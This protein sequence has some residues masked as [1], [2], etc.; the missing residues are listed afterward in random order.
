MAR[1]RKPTS[2]FR[3][4]NSSPEVIC[5]VVMMYVKHPLSLRSA[6]NILFKHHGTPKTITTDG[7]RSYRV[8]MHELGNADK[9]ELGRWANNWI[10]KSHLP[11]RLRERAMLRFKKM[12][13]PQKVA[14]VHANLHNHFNQ[15]RHVVARQTYKAHRSSALAEWQTLMS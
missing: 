13:S 9:Q 15:E 8:A 4:F 10:E 12:K 3:E 6:E 7:L 2:P 11:F 1:P 14:S 5:L